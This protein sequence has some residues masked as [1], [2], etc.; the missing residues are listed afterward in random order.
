MRDFVHLHLHSEYSFLDGACRITDI[1]R[2]AKEK[3]QSAVALTDHG[4]MYGCVDFYRACQKEGIKAI[5]GCEVYFSPKSR[6]STEKDYMHLILLAKDRKGYEN[7]I[8]L[9]SSGF[10]EGFYFKPRIDRELLEGHSEGLIALSACIYGV[11]S[12][13][14]LAKDME[15]AFS[16][17]KMLKDMFKEDFY[18]ELQDHGLEEERIAN[19]G[20]LKISKELGIPLV[21]TNDVHYLTKK[22]SEVQALLSDIKKSSDSED[23]P[24]LQKEFYLKSGDEMYYIFK[25][26]P[27][28]IENTVKI[29]EK[30]NFEFEFG[31]TLL[32]EFDLPEGKTADGYLS[33]LAKKGLERLIEEG[34]IDPAHTPEDY[35]FRMIYELMVISKMG[36]SGYYLIVQDFVGYAKSRGIPVG[37]GRGSGAGSL[38][39]YLVGIT[40]VDPIRHGLLFERFLNPE[41]VS[42]PDFDIDFCYDRRN[43]VINY[44]KEKYGSD[45]VCQI[46]AFGTFL[47]K[48]SLRYAGASLGMP[49]AEADKIVKLIPRG[50]AEALNITISDAMEQV[51][52]LK[53]QYQNEPTVKRLIDTAMKLEGLH[54]HITTH[55]AG[56]VIAKDPIYKT[57]PL[58]KSGDVVLTQYD[59]NTV[60]DLGLLKFDF[61][62]I[63]YLT[64]IAG[65]ERLVRKKEKDFSVEKIPLDDR[66]TYAMIGRGNSG[67]V[68]QLESEGMKKLLAM[69]K[70]E[71]IGDIMTAISLYRPGPMDSISRYVECKN[72]KSKITYECEALEEILSE[73]FGCIVYQ[74]QVMQIFRKLASYSYGRADVVRRVMAKKKVLEMEKERESFVEGSYKNGIEREVANRIFDSMASFASYA[75]CKSHAAAYSYTSYRSAYLKCHYPAE[76]YSVLLTSVSRNSAK[77]SEYIQDAAKMGVKTNG[78]DINNSDWDF[79]AKDGVIYFGLSGIKNIGDGFAEAIVR[80]RRENGKYKSFYDFMNRITKGSVNKTQLHSLIGAGAF[81]SLSEYRSRLLRCYEEMLVKLQDKRRRQLDGQIDLFAQFEDAEPDISMPDM[82]EVPEL[83]KNQRLSLEK[84]LTGLYFSGH[85]LDNYSK[86]IEELSSMSL[87]DLAKKVESDELKDRQRVRIYGLVNKVNIRKTSSGSMMATAV[88]E[89]GYSECELVFFKNKLTEYESILAEGIAVYVEGGISFRDENDYSVLVNTM[90]LLQDNGSFKERIKKSE[91][92]SEQK[93]VAKEKDGKKASA[94]TKIYAKLQDTEGGQF[95]RIKAFSEIF[96]GNVP[97][98][99]YDSKTGKYTDFGFRV[100]PTAFVVEKL[101]GILSKEDVVVK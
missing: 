78:P 65:A 29:A 52:A 42:M 98:I 87:T 4:V 97:L 93:T 36:Y 37:P 33:D 8:Y 99:I 43:E 57:V 81:D 82:S 59:M 24:F 21:A 100:S 25:D 92:A 40:T 3:G 34:R 16:N 51:P 71:N 22:D 48:N 73:T 1:A 38:V 28:A 60:A 55:A 66:E 5:I 83:S 41:R 54:A 7:L 90:G 19:E 72:D 61:L 14:I 46:A 13:N 86:N 68:F 58:C 44:V 35:K 70:P 89:D 79:T 69:M 74:E 20:L 32:P 26:H 27:E 49:Y 15:G 96:T 95:K 53:E 12:K 39:A 2:A 75:F 77:M 84:E 62:A 9:V 67:G 10:T 85:P 80:E 30:C 91:N 64:V 17:A 101:R 31:K 76:Y 94:P 47:A 18:I 50:S 63:R 11:L 6:F 88:L 45:R 23:N 56:I